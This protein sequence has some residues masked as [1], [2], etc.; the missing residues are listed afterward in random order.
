MNAKTI[1]KRLSELRGE[2]TQKDVA[3]AI[4]VCQSTYSMYE[5][6]ERIPSD[7]VKKKIAEYFKR[8][9]QFIF[10]EE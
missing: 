2:R 3:S 6:G 8:S 4:G 7:E 9:V 1:G 5:N 10:Y